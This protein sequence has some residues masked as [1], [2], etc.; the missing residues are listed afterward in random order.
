[1]TIY[2]ALEKYECD[3]RDFVETTEVID[4]LKEL[5]KEEQDERA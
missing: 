1:M 3:M 5:L 2:Q 4:L